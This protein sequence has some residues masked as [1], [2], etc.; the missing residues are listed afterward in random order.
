MPNMGSL[1]LLDGRATSVGYAKLPRRRVR[2]VG[3]PGSLRYHKSDQQL[4]QN[5]LER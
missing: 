2:V 3:K 4:I 5:A 1:S